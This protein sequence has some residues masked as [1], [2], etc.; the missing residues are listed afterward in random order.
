MSIYL[1]RREFIAA[2]GGAAA[3]PLAAHAQQPKLPVI[4]F[5]DPRS[6]DVI[7]DLLLAFRQ[8]LKE[9]GHADG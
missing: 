3:L 5:L 4:G 2:L 1:G 8:G 7:P 9:T 6:S